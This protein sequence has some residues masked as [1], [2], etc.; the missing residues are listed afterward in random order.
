LGFEKNEPI[1][2]PIWFF[3]W[4]R[5]AYWSNAHQAWYEDYNCVGTNES[6][7]RYHKIC[8]LGE[9][10]GCQ[11]GRKTRLWVIQGWPYMRVASKQRKRAHQ[12]KW[13]THC[14]AVNFS[15]LRAN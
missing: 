7:L 14:A 2:I 9:I 10:G 3:V 11:C 1:F 15:A 13:Q 8:L 4:L 5:K 12:K 6:G